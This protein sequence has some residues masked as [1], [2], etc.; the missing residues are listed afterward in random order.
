MAEAREK[1]GA[2]LMSIGLMKSA[3]ERGLLCA[4]GADAKGDGALVSK[5]ILV[6]RPKIEK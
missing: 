1:A 6:R 2:V 3:E 4:T 5:K